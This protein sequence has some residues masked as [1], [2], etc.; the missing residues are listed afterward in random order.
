MSLSIIACYKHFHKSD[1]NLRSIYLKFFRRNFGQIYYIYVHSNY[2]L[3]KVLK[4]VLTNFHRNFVRIQKS[5]QSIAPLSFQSINYVPCEIRKI[6]IF[7]D[8]NLLL[9][10]GLH[11]YSHRLFN[12]V[13]EK[14]DT[15][16]ITILL[17]REKSQATSKFSIRCHGAV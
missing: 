12:N 2:F 7:L 4:I 14:T 17:V 15:K 16:R 9:Q 11:S 8:S 5:Y 3:L 6:V 10:I 1:S 13:L